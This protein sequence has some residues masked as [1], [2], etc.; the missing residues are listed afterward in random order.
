[1]GPPPEFINKIQMDFL[2]MGKHWVSAG[3]ACLP[4]EEGGQGVVCVRSQ[5]HTFRLQYLQ[6]YLFAD[7]SLQWCQL[8]TSFFRQLRSMRYDRQL[9]IIRPEGL[10]RNLSELP[11]Y[12]RDLL[13]AWKLVSATRKEQAAGVDILAEP[14][15]YNPA[16][17]ARM[18]DSPSICRRLILAQVTRVGDL[19]DYERRDWVSAEV[20]APR[21]GMLTARVPRRLIREIKD[22]IHPDSRTFIEGGFADRRA[23]STYQLQLSGSLRGS[24]TT[25]TPSGSYLP[26]PQQVGGYVPG[27]FSRHAKESPVFSGAPYSALPRPCHPPRYHLE[28]FESCDEGSKGYLSREDM[29]V[30]VVM[31]FG[32][33]PSKVCHLTGF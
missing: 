2:W 25:A 19:L 10:G 31:L 30:A 5:L 27:M 1:M 18:L 3:V 15:L 8:A 33:K 26:Q 6:R 17:G 21:M 28:V 22:A 32:Y 13:K 4:L 29:K 16:V 23:L 9:F 14:L 7:P 20:L 12:Y 24:Q 11:A